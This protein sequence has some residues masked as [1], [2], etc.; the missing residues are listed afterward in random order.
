ML[1]IG[2]RWRR[3]LDILTDHDRRLRERWVAEWAVGLPVGAVVLDA[4]AGDGHLESVFS[5]QRY[6]ALDIRP[7]PASI[8]GDRLFLCADLHNVPLAA[9]S[10]D[11]AVSVQ[12]LEHVWDPAQVFVELARVV[13]PGGT[14][15]L[16]VPQ[17][18]PEHEQPFDF[19]RFTTFSLRMLAGRAGLDI[20]DIRK[21]GGYFSRLSA[22][23]RDLPFVVLPENRSYRFGFGAAILR[24][25]LVVVFTFIT[26]RAL[27][28]FDRFDSV[29]TY[30]GGYFCVLKVPK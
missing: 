20:V 25:M 3:R 8:R 24:V 15:C 16:S 6:L 28:F 7:R 30:T 14:I 1:N 29:R 10:V 9:D 19:F 2:K 22:E 11:H 27:I 17:A 21:K 13:R 26:A 12:V 18:D 23:I 4:G 5:A